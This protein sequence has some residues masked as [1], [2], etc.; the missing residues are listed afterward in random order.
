MT[1]G[2]D[3]CSCRTTWTRPCKPERCLLSGVHERELGANIQEFPRYLMM[4]Y[5]IV[6]QTWCSCSFSLHDRC[7]ARASSVISHPKRTSFVDQV[8]VGVGSIG[9]CLLLWA[10]NTV[11]WVTFNLNPNIKPWILVL[12]EPVYAIEHS[13]IYWFLTQSGHLLLLAR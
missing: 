13:E 11:W 9:W 4:I 12:M 2:E 1:L 6:P 3:V 5:Y 10:H 8:E 7:C